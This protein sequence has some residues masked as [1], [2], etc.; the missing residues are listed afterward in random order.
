MSL[1]VKRA[2]SANLIDQLSCSVDNL[3][4]CVT[5]KIKSKNKK[6]TIISCVYRKPGTNIEEF[7]ERIDSMFE[8]F[9]H[10]NLY[11]CQKARE[12]NITFYGIKIQFSPITSVSLNLQ[13][14]SMRNY[15]YEKALFN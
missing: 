7:T 14:K 5:V 12:K 1:F 3:F 9:K 11:L 6:Q 4:E 10:K 2:F 8:P 13:G 15:T